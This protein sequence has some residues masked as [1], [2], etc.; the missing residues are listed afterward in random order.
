MKKLLLLT[1]GE[2]RPGTARITLAALVLTGLTLAVAPSAGA[3][4]V[5]GE[6][7]FEVDVLYDAGDV[8]AGDCVCDD[9]TGNCPLRAAVEE[10]NADGDQDTI[11]FLPG[12]R[13]HNLTAGEIVIGTN[14]VVQGRRMDKT[15]IDATNNYDAAC[16]SS[17]EVD[18]RIF[19]TTTGGIGG[20]VDIALRDLTL[21]NG[22]TYANNSGGP[23][24]CAIRKW[25]GCLRNSTADLTIYRVRFKDCMALCAA[26]VSGCSADAG[27]LSNDDGAV[28]IMYSSFEGNA[29]VDDG[30]AVQNGDVSSP[31]LASMTI[32]QTTFANNEAPGDPAPASGAGGAI[33]NREGAG[34]FIGDNCHFNNNS[35][36]GRGGAISNRNTSGGGG[37]TDTIFNNNH[38]EDGADCGGAIAGTNGLNTFGNAFHHNTPNDT[39]G[40]S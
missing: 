24:D 19:T 25:G 30:G 39:R 5:C 17:P 22:T 29:A 2:F 34:L 20:D 27:A 36:G 37:V 32:G 15:I 26:G 8:A 40:G 7:T 9:G 12:K 16:G 1:L 38:C 6:Q 23:Y 31:F 33:I 18:G 14:L 11:T 35:T 28:T 21:R 10:A 4:G 3:N 13:I